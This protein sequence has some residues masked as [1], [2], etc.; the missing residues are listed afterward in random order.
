MLLLCTTTSILCACST[1]GPAGPPSPPGTAVVHDT[2][3]DLEA[4]AEFNRQYLKA[5]NEGDSATL[6]ALTLD[7]IVTIEPNWKPIEGKAANDK[8]NR[9]S[10][11]LFRIEEKWT[12]TETV[13][14]GDLAYQRGV[15]TESATPRA[16]GPSRTTRGN[17][18]RIFRRQPDGSWRMTRDMTSSDQPVALPRARGDR[19]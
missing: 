1:T 12:P 14:V 13:I 3:R 6:S 11:Q 15:F 9:Q 2:A 17:Y 7:D 19:S 18:L 16:G 8:A 5:V 4:I 10:L